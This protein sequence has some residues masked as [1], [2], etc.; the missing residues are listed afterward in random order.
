MLELLSS[1]DLEQGGEIAERLRSIYAWSLDE[2]AQ[3]RVAADADR[4]DAVAALLA[5]LRESWA[6]LAAG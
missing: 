5:E 4:I 3:A 2:L 1:L 6:A